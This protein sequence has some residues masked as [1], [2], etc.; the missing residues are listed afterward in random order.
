ML[1][2]IDYMYE[3]WQK[4]QR[5]EYTTCTCTIIQEVQ[6]W[7]YIEK[8]MLLYF[9]GG[10]LVKVNLL[11]QKA[12]WQWTTTVINDNGVFVAHDRC[13]DIV[14]TVLWPAYVYDF[15]GNVIETSKIYLKYIV[16]VN[17]KCCEQMPTPLIKGKE[18]L[19]LHNSLPKCNCPW[20]KF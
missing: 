7:V 13:H 18:I 17:R 11:G 2:I 5:D 9:S 8:C 3:K 19:N 1:L 20:Y 16:W 4:C 10:L 15:N 12:E 6:L 14:K